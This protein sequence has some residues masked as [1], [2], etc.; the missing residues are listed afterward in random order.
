VTGDGIEDEVI[1]KEE[2]GKD[3]F[4]D[5][6][7]EKEIM[8][9]DKAPK[10]WEDSKKEFRE[11]VLETKPDENKGEE[12]FREHRVKGEGSEDATEDTVERHG[13]Q[14]KYNSR[15]PTGRKE[16][17]KNHRR[18]VHEKS[19]KKDVV[20]VINPDSNHDKV[21][22]EV[23]VE[24]KMIVKME[25]LKQVQ[26]EQAMTDPGEHFVKGDG[27]EDAPKGPKQDS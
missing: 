8:K 22:V 14:N 3:A 25:N 11:G 2:A 26:T 4:E 17:P 5:T 10:N 9:Q 12:N 16:Q 23:D 6:E 7:D 13:S 19:E 15:A 18:S 21:D 24:K 27:L 1:S 20:V